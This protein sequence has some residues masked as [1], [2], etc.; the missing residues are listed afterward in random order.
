MYFFISVSS[1][2]AVDVGLSKFAK[3][4]RSVTR[5]RQFNAGIQNIKDPSK[6]S[7]LAQVR[8]NSIFEFFFIKI[9][10]NLRILY[11]FFIDDVINR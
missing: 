4:A 3:L 11:S 7:N 1:P 10:C 9:Q 5:S 6:Q 8:I 2:A